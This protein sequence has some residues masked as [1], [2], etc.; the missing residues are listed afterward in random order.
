MK[1]MRL[2]NVLFIVAVFCASNVFAQDYQLRLNDTSINIATGNEYEVTV[3]GQRI[4]LSLSLKDTLEFSQSGFSFLYPRG[5]TPAKHLIDSTAEQFT[6]LTAEGSGIILQHYFSLN[7]KMM[8]ELMLREM[9]KESID[10]GYKMQREEYKTTIKSG[11][12]VNVIKA[13]LTYKDD[14][15]IY[16]VAAIGKKDEGLMIITINSSNTSSEGKKLINLLWS[17]LKY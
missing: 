3:N 7:P 10:Y 14:V 4:K 13:T 15:S 6:I 16:E 17:T 9:T 8:E 2:K 5:Y 12:E 11:Q 1:M